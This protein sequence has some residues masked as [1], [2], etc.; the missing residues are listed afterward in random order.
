M[1]LYTVTKSDIAKR[2]SLL[3]RDNKIVF[4]MS[5]VIL[6]V[7]I[8]FFSLT[9]SRVEKRYGK[10]LKQDRDKLEEFYNTE[11]QKYELQNQSLSKSIDSLIAVTNLQLQSLIEK[12]GLIDTRLEQQLNAINTRH[13]KAIDAI[14]SGSFDDNFSMFSNYLNSTELPSE[15]SK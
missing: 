9:P 1:R 15:D 4:T 6:L 2:L 7:S 8:L 10:L 12:D 11:I 14:K 13:E 5:L 3:K